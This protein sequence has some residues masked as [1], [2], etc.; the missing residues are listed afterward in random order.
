MID[1]DRPGLCPPLLASPPLGG[2]GD[3]RSPIAAGVFSDS[4]GRCPR[5]CGGG[6]CEAYDEL[7][8]AVGRVEEWTGGSFRWRSPP[9]T[10][11]FCLRAGERS[12][13]SGGATFLKVIVHSTSS[14]A[15]T[16]AFCHVTNT[17]MFEADMV[18][19]RLGGLGAGCGVWSS[20]SGALVKRHDACRMRAAEEW[21]QSQLHGGRG[22][23]TRAGDVKM[24]RH[25]P[26]RCPHP[27][28]A[29]PGTS[30][31]PGSSPHAFV[32]RIPT[33]RQRK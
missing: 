9:G 18:W 30:M 20:S 26:P 12:R 19:G 15:N 22:G 16:V 17:R 25:A 1:S 33:P 6:F 14:P 5:R 24:L 8:D 11:P 27:P 31:A 2:T 28:C 4:A 23:A 10:K 13:P 21:Q 7:R 29:I 32:P 3:L